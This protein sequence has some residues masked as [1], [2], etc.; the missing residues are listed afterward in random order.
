MRRFT[1]ILPGNEGEIECE[2]S[3]EGEARFNF[4]AIIGGRLPH[5]SIVMFG[6][7]TRV[8]YFI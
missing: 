8:I 1:L 7:R 4:K 3:D 2:A 5:G 6:V